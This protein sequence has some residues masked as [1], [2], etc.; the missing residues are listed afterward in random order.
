MTLNPRLDDP[1]TPLVS[2]IVPNYNYG[3]FLV[4][5]FESI[6][7]QSY[8]NIEIIFS[9]N[10][11]CDESWNIA[12]D[13]SKRHPKVFSIVRNR[14]NFGSAANHNRSFSNA[15]G[16]YVS[17]LA[18]DDVL[19]PDFVKTCVSAFNAQP[20]I[21]FVF[22]HRAVLDENGKRSD[23]LPFYNITCKIQGWAQS[24]VYMMASPNHSISQIM[25]RSESLLPMLPVNGVG[26]RHLGMKIADFHICCNHPIVYIKEPLV[27]NRVHGT[28]DRV[29]A[30]LLLM[31]IIAPYAINLHFAEVA[32]ITGMSE[33]ERRLPEA[34][35]K[36]GHLSLRYSLRALLRNDT[37]TAARYFHL[38]AA[39][40]PEIV[41]DNLFEGLSRYLYAFITDDEKKRLM[42]EWMAT[43]N[44][45][46]RA[47]SYDPPQGSMPLNII[48]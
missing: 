15:R 44:F 3:R 37:R 16:R 35:M 42:E 5:C 36:L 34:T 12:I 1:A 30:E 13:Y 21:G 8:N 47:T 2:I 43:Q 22:T 20:D 41:T 31:D 27:L 40:Y 48:H 29:S 26:S 23:D 32:S 28:N 6:L 14:I 9:D 7:N 24:A 19:L 10:A 25:Y 4:E 45:L 18:S 46:K 33:V 11:S 38:S 17:I 39:M